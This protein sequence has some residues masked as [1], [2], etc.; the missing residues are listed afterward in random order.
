MNRDLVFSN[1]IEDHP[2]LD[3][4]PM[5]LCRDLLRSLK[6]VN[7]GSLKSLH[8]ELIRRVVGQRNIVSGD[9]SQGG[10][11]SLEVLPFGRRSV[12]VSRC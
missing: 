10:S 11:F 1:R 8:P 7:Q 4:C 9:I 2:A 6:H 3:H 5:I 12:A